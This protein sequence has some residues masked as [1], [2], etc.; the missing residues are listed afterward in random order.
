MPAGW[1]AMQKTIRECSYYKIDADD[2]APDLEASER[3]RAS[4]KK[5]GLTR[6]FTAPYA[7]ISPIMFV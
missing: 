7:L 3:D 2:E 4:K 1:Q 5:P 6:W